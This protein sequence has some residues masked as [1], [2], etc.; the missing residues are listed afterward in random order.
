MGD[1]NSNTEWELKEQWETL[2]DVLMLPKED[3]LLLFKTCGL[4]IQRNMKDG[5]VYHVSVDSFDKFAIQYDLEDVMVVTRKKL[6][7]MISM[8]PFLRLGRY[9]GEGE[10]NVQDQ[11]ELYG[12][13]KRAP[14][15]SKPV[16][17]EEFSADY[18]KVFHSPRKER[19]PTTESSKQSSH[20]GVSG[21]VIDPAIENIILCERITELEKKLEDAEAH[22]KQ[23]EVPEEGFYN[24]LRYRLFSINSSHD[25]R[26]K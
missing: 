5:V 14:R 7:G 20:E 18:V 16:L 22:I 11:A 17:R 6:K 1:D 3:F 10:Y 15:M 13:N 24:K 8:R 2:N 26:F 25:V 9:T 19:N 4:I 23:L 21:E 12:S